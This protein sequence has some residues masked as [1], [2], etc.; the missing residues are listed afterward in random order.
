MYP[1]RHIS[2][3][4]TAF[5]QPFKDEAQAALFNDPVRNVQ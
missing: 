4:V 5:A 3:M 1:Q 2:G